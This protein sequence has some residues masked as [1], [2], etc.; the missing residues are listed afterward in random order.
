MGFYLLLLYYY[1]MAAV[2]SYIY[3]ANMNF[4]FL[5]M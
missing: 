5:N 4:T 2:D 1:V 3:K